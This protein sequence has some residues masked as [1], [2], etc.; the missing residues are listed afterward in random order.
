MLT[1]DDVDIRAER[2]ESL[3]LVEDDGWAVA[4]DLE[5]DDTL[6]AEGTARELVRAL[7]DLRR[8]EGLELSDR[9]EVTI[10]ADEALRSVIDAHRD[11]IASEVLAIGIVY[12]DGTRRVELDDASVDVTLRVV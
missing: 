10:D 5:L 9:I 7:N 2:H 11:T 1:A 4:L 8:T 3:A 6:R 12:G